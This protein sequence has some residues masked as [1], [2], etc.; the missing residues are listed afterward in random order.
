VAEIKLGTRLRSAVCNTEVIVTKGSPFEGA[1]T[2]GGQPMVLSEGAGAAPATRSGD[3]A[4]DKT[5]LGKR[6]RT[7]DGSIEMLC[8]HQGRG[9]LA[10]DG[11]PLELVKPKLLPA[12]D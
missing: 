10:I 4:L 6:Y 12:S 11:M 1:L 3:I 7:A 9:A 2:C 8:V 5:L